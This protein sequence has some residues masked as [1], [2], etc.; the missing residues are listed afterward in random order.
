[1]KKT[2]NQILD[3]SSYNKKYMLLTLIAVS[4]LLRLATVYF[5]RD[6]QID[7][8]WKVLLNNL[9]NYNSY[10]Y[11][12][13]N[14]KLIPSALLPPLYPFFLYVIKTVTSLEGPSLINLIIFI[15]II[16][17]TYSVYLFFQINLNFFEIK[18]SLINSLIFSIIPLNIYACGQTSSICLQMFF[19]LFFLK[20]LFQLLKTQNKKNIIFFSLASSMTI[21]I[22]GEFILLFILTIFFIYLNKKIKTINILKIITI[23]ILV[24]SPYVVRNYIQFNQF[25]IVKSLGYNLWKGNNQLSTVGGYEDFK[26]LE[27]THLNNK[28]TKIKKNKYYEINRDNIFL[29]EATSNITAKPIYYFKLYIKKF[30]TYFF[31]DINSKYPNYNNFLHLFP[32]IVISIISA[33]GLFIVLKKKS[34]KSRY[35]IFL[36]LFN[37]IIFSVFFILPRYKLV[38]LPM[39]IILAAYFANYVLKKL[40]INIF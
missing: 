2:I 27:F 36:L 13:F 33:P 22:R 4:F 38:I 35:L 26:S 15:Q 24:I 7:N 10:S 30:F 8:E 18:L 37:I 25:F 20:L 29:K 39:Q 21:L 28:I 12:T 17:S 5:V 32:I 11:Y 1:M 14:N 31:I 23:T 3:N 16:L 40:K 9:V 6:F 19:F 34:F